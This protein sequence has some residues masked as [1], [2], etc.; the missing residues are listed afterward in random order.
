MRENAYPISWQGVEM[1]Q[2]ERITLDQV[3]YSDFQTMSNWPSPMYA[4]LP[5]RWQF[6]AMW[7][8]ETPNYKEKIGRGEIVNNAMYKIQYDV[9]ALLVKRGDTHV[10]K[11]TSAQYAFWQIAG[12]DLWGTLPRTM[13]GIDAFLED[14]D[15]EREIAVTKS[16]ANVDAASI[17]ALASLGELPETISWIA[18]VMRRMISILRAIKAK[19]VLK[20]G[21]KYFRKKG[22]LTRDAAGYWMEIRYSVRPLLFEMEQAVEALQ[23]VLNKGKRVTSRG[24]HEVFDSGRHILHVQDYGEAFTSDL[25]YTK[26]RHSVYRGGVIFEVDPEINGVMALWGLDQPLETIWELTT[27]SFM[28]DW[29]FNVGDTIASW[30]S[31]PSLNPLTNWVTEVHNIIIQPT[32]VGEPSPSTWESSIWIMQDP[33]SNLVVSDSSAMVIKRRTVCPP[34]PIIPNFNMNLNWAKLLDLAIV[35]RG[36]FRSL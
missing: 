30:T 26:W 19:T 14:F 25:S 10:Y 2:R 27:L 33:Y 34:R 5:T 16:W 7:D 36:L 15:S 3:T 6:A 11:P 28:I 29:F 32:S 13:A 9:S 35:G 1:S 24:K 31:N 8:T 23:T 17:Q 22:R 18:S 4:N 20:N 21:I 12:Y